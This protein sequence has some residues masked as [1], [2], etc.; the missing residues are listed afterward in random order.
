[1]SHP[2]FYPL[3]SPPAKSD[4]TSYLS[5]RPGEPLRSLALGSKIPRIFVFLL[6]AAWGGC[7]ARRIPKLAPVV[8]E[9]C[10]RKWSFL[11]RR[12]L[13]AYPQLIR[14]GIDTSFKL[15]RL[16]SS[17]RTP[18]GK[19]ERHTEVGNC[20][21][22]ESEDVSLK[23]SAPP[24]THRRGFLTEPTTITAGACCGP[25]GPTLPIPLGGST[26]PRVDHMPPKTHAFG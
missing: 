12:R 9:V 22:R 23:L 15:G 20:P 10:H 16:N 11:D 17:P 25:Q 3:D 19:T 5:I 4:H 2:S 6:D 8:Q 21:S 24:H 13:S 1:M 18:N 26:P 14:T 7:L